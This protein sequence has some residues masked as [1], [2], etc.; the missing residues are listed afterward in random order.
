MYYPGQSVLV[1]FNGME[2]TPA[3]IEAHQKE[4]VIVRVE[5]RTGFSFRR[6]PVELV[7]FDHFSFDD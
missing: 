5:R 3:T 6:V 7:I 1:P 4:Y 2:L